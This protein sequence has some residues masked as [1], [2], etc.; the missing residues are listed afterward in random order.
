[1]YFS[2]QIRHWQDKEDE[3]DEFYDL[4]IEEVVADV[5]EGNFQF[6][7]IHAYFF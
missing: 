4:S 6:L 3:D 1:M 7:G 2:L 5:S